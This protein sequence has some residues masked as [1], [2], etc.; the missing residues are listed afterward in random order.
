MSDETTIDQSAA[1]AMQAAGQRRVE[2]KQAVSAVEVAAARAAAEPACGSQPR[3]RARATSRRHSRT[4]H[5]ARGPTVCL[6]SSHSD[7]PRLIH[8]IDMVKN[9]HQRCST[10]QECDSPQSMASRR[11][12]HRASRSHLLLAIARHRQRISDLVY[13]AYNTDLG[14]GGPRR[15]ATDLGDCRPRLRLK[16]PA[17]ARPCRQRR[18]SLHVEGFGDLDAAARREDRTTLG[19]GSPPRRCRRPRSGCSRSAGWRPAVADRHR[20]RRRSGLADRVAAV[21]DGLAHRTEPG[22]PGLHHFGLLL[23]RSRASP[24]PW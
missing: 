6:P 7:A 19:V 12:P 5:R 18:T 22:L 16:R 24:P 1:Q 20:R 14:G 23:P 15:G 2:L 4:A 9:G 11:D 8:K 17:F 13:E 3:R 10:E 21:E